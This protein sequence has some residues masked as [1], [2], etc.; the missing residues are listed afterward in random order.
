[1]FTY[2]FLLLHHLIS[3]NNTSFASGIISIWKKVVHHLS[4]THLVNLMQA[5]HTLYA[6]THLTLCMHARS[7]H[8][9]CMHATCTLL[10]LCMH[11]RVSHSVCMNTAHT[12]YACMSHAHWSHSV[13]MHAAHTLYACTQLTL[14]MYACMPHAQLTLCMHAGGSHSVCMHA[15]QCYD[16]W[17]P[18]R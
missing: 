17:R 12:L 18:G 3:T 7:S 1:M 16:C 15:D 11:A 14:C 6:C 10:T 9:V 4:Y 2:V 13:W 5:A 8:S